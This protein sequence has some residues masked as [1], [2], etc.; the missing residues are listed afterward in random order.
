MGEIVSNNKLIVKNASLLYVR[1]GIV[2][3]LNLY[4]SR[5]VLKNLGVEDFGIYNVVGGVVAMFAY[6]NSALTAATQRYLNYE[7]GQMNDNSLNKVFCMSLN[8][9]LVLAFI[10]LVFLETLGLWFLNSHIVI[11]EDRIYAANWVF[12]FSIISTF[13]QIITIPYSALV[14]AHERMSVIAYISILDVLLKLLLVFLLQFSSKDNLILYALYMM[15]VLLSIRLLYMI[16]CRIR[17]KESKYQLLWDNLLFR[18]MFGFTAWNFMGATAGIAM[19]QGVN[20]LLNL[21]GGPIVNASRAIAI[22]IQNA[23]AQLA[24]SFISAVNPQIV[25]NFSSGNKERMTNLV[26]TSSKYAFLIMAVTAMPILVKMDFVLGIWL[27][28]VPMNASKFAKLLLIYQLTICLTYSLNMASQASGKIRLFQIVESL[29]LLFIIPIGWI[30]LKSGLEES[31]I[32]A[33]MIILSSAALFLRLLV[34]KKIIDFQIGRFAREVLCPISI[35][36]VL[37]VLI[38]VVSIR[39]SIYDQNVALN[40]FQMVVILVVSLIIAYAIGLNSRERMKINS[41]IVEKI[42]QS[43]KI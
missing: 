8:I 39:F 3:I 26:V 42:R 29:T 2:M 16:Y 17:Y 21:F 9:H 37:F 7:M 43:L 11:P 6:L 36:S 30:L 38:Y 10:I 23:F 13:I 22:Q 34:L 18:E 14:T 4:I 40:I 25:K 5:L 32:F 20:I 28:D 24:T 41:I 27:T 19:N 15:I 31:S 35:V 12:Q 1:M 33:A